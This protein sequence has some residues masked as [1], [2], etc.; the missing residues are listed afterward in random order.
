MGVGMIGKRFEGICWDEGDIL[1][2]FV[3]WGFIGLCVCYSLLYDMFKVCVFY[4]KFR[5]K[6][7]I[8][9]N[10]KYVEIFRDSVL[11]YIVYF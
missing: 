5:F 3:S 8:L 10:D 7:G 4:Y 1:Y 6:K 9:V 2:F 11:M